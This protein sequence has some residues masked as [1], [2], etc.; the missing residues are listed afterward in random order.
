[1]KRI[2]IAR[3]A[4][5]LISA[6][7]LSHA[8]YVAPVPQEESLLRISA[9][10][11]GA[12]VVNVSD[13]VGRP[14]AGANVTISGNATTW[15]TGSDGSVR[16]ENISAGTTPRTV[17][18]D[19]QGYLPASALIV[20]EE[21]VTKF[22]NLAI[23]GGTLYG[24]V[25]T[26]SN[27]PIVNATIQ[28]AGYPQFSTLSS[29][30]GNYTI[31]GIPTGS[32]AVSAFAQLY[33]PTTFIVSIAA[34]SFVLQTFKLA[35][36]YGS[37][38]GYVMEGST[39]IH[40]ANVTITINK[41]RYVAE[42]DNTG[43]YVLPNV[44]EG[45]Y[46]VTASKE[47][48]SS[49]TVSDV[50]VEN[51]NVTHVNFDLSSLPSSLM[52]VVT[53]SISIGT[54][55]VFNA[56]VEILTTGLS[57]NTTTQG[58][59]LITDVPI[60]VFAV[61]TSAP[62][63]EDNIT[64]GIAFERGKTVRLDIVLIAKPGQLIGIVRDK[65]TSEPVSGYTVI[66]SGPE[67]RETKTGEDG[68]YVFAGLMPGN[69]SITVKG[70]AHGSKYSPFLATG[71]VV[72]ADGVTQY[73]VYLLLAKEALG[74][75]IFG[76]DLPHSFMVLA[77]IIMIIILGLAIYLRLRAFQNPA[78]AKKDLEEEIAAEAAEEKREEER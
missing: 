20:I 65:V 48:Y 50:I 24:V 21:N 67:Q 22:V 57:A 55:L 2:D 78:K 53:A 66:V 59:Y 46:S 14:I 13:E 17:N 11:V 31:R 3:F 54:V 40:G 72:T 30:D 71:I 28:I 33:S 12:L 68:R 70:S 60:G 7:V 4:A 19:K 64:S 35:K 52:G 45:N 6:L 15:Q 61:R 37:I 74:G 36:M 75:F 32:Y 10:A 58:T 44:P 63:Y 16:I 69:Y 34:G 29:W 49:Q 26:E 23:T 18:A 41:I 43:Y 5:I 62:G 56:K 8:W 38:D 9:G 77:F 25:L 27:S 51:G 39:P 76:M 42:S 73:D 1:M 47:G